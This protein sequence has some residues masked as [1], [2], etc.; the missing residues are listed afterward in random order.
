MLHARARL[1]LN[2][3]QT[4]PTG[5]PKYLCRVFHRSDDKRMGATVRPHRYYFSD[6]WPGKALAAGS[7][8]VLAKFA[9]VPASPAPVAISFSLPT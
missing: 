8:Y 4:H 7:K 2:P 6:E 1:S 3:Q 9:A 5:A